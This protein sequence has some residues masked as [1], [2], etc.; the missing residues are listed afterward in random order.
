MSAEADFSQFDAASDA[1]ENA[2]D[3][4]TM[5]RALASMRQAADGICRMSGEGSEACRR[6]RRKAS[7]AA[8]NVAA[9]GC[10]CDGSSPPIA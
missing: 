2:G 1:L 9:A 4:S 3:C 7:D 10:D 6:A 5:C 8:R